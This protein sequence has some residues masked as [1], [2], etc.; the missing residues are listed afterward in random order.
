LT[1]IGLFGEYILCSILYLIWGLFNPDLL[2]DIIVIIFFYPAFFWGCLIVSLGYLWIQIIISV[3]I[4]YFLPWYIP[5]FVS[6]YSWLS[7]IACG[8]LILH[9]AAI[10]ILPRI[11]P[12]IILNPFYRYEK[13][14]E[15]CICSARDFFNKLTQ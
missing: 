9:I 2:V 8:N 13:W 7:V 4:L 12:G 1:P 10:L 5:A 3:F 15:I 14:W 6:V 11:Y